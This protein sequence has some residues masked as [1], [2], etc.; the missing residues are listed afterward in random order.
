MTARQLFQELAL[1]VSVGLVA[2]T[3]AA[4]TPPAV[5]N[6]SD[7]AL[8]LWL[9]STSL[10][11]AGLV[12]GSQVTSW[13]DKSSYGTILA[14]RT[15]TNPAGPFI[16][17]PVEENPHLRYVTINGKSVPTVRF[18]R[19]G[20]TSNTGNPAIDG[21]GAADRLY[22]TNNL[23]PGFDPLDIGDGSSMTTFAVV[24]P[25]WT[26]T[27]NP[28]GGPVNTNS[29]NVIFGKRGPNASVYTLGYRNFQG[30]GFWNFTQYDG[31]VS[32]F[33]K[34]TAVEKTWN[35]VSQIVT[36]NPGSSD[37]DTI[38]FYAASAMSPTQTLAELGTQRGPDG[39]TNNVINGRNGSVPE[40]FG[41]GGHSQS[42]CGELE[43]FAGSIAEIII[44]AK[45]L[46]PT[47][48][49]QVA[50]YL[51]QKYFT[52]P[53]SGLAGD[54]DGSGAVNGLDLTVWKDQMGDPVGA[55]HHA[56]GN[57]DGKIDGLDFLIWQ[58]GLGGSSTP[59]STVP[60]P[61]A[62]MLALCGLSTLLMRRQHRP[63]LW[64]NKVKQK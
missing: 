63:A 56:D 64:G 53:T 38:D 5:L 33:S 29:Y 13:V 23:T 42:C 16:G 9:D 46:T 15:N 27:T 43:A 8:R 18:D 28:Q 59:I 32:Y 21:S 50:S 35:V 7:P 19:N 40:P 11:T 61:A 12:E 37:V 2:T 41:V 36:D 60:E 51:S 14:P 25:D 34:V 6:P 39:I 30:N 20:V 4:Q 62:G 52:P 54:Y 22:Q 24:N 17:D 57:N 26:T 1:F 45:K 31:P 10:V 49:A 44:F 47:E 58:R 55:A 48:H 3:V